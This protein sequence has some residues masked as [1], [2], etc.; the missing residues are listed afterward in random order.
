MDKCKPLVH[1][2]GEDTGMADGSVDVVSLAFVIH[3]CP[4]S[5]TRALMR[6]VGRC[7]LTLSNPY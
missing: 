5:A 6:E 7:R 3:E 1:G 2:L 4:E